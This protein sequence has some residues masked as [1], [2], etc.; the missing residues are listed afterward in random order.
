MISTT[1]TDFLIWDLVCM[2]EFSHICFR[3]EF[4][5]KQT[6][7]IKGQKKVMLG[8]PFWVILIFNSVKAKVFT[9]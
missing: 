6:E 2:E 5:D 1:D 7:K 8:Y 4:T 9:F 3:K